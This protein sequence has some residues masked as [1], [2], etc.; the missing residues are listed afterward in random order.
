MRN[1]GFKIFIIIS[2]MLHTMLFGLFLLPGFSSK[3]KPVSV[4]YEVDIVAGPGM[5]GMSGPRSNRAAARINNPKVEG[6]SEI[7]K[8]SLSGEKEPLL[9]SP[10]LDTLPEQPSGERRQASGKNSQTDGNESSSSSSS[11]GSVRGGGAWVGVVVNRVSDA[12]Q[13]PK[14]VPINQNLKVTYTIT[15]SRSGDI[16]GIKLRVPSGNKPYDRSVELALGRVKL[17][18]PPAGLEEL[19]FTFVPPYVK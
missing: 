8:D 10:D 17:P 5:Q 3:P 7:S 16:I 4:V 12:W 11:R 18:P 19:T 6:F 13:I 14:G 9:S 2:L 15:I 1:K